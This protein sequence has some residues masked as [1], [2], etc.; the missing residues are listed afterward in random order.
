MT[1][2]FAVTG[3]A[4][5]KRYACVHVDHK[6]YFHLLNDLSSSQDRVVMWKQ[7]RYA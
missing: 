5:Y 7:N 6:V 1:E 4:C 3:K 2:Q